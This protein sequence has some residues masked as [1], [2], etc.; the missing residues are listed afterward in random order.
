M[1]IHR[2][3][4]HD[5]KGVSFDLP[6]ASAMVFFGPND[7]G[8]TNTLEAFLSE[9]GPARSVRGQDEPQEIRTELELE[10]DGLAI[11][12]HHDQE[13][14]LT[15]LLAHTFV[16]PYAE[17]DEGSAG[18]HEVLDRFKAYREAAF[19][20][21]EA[22]PF[23][24]TRPD[25]VARLVDEVLEQLGLVWDELI[26]VGADAGELAA[27]SGPRL[28]Q[29]PRF[30]MSF[31]RIEWL[32]PGDRHRGSEYVW[33]IE[34]GGPPVWQRY[35]TDNLF[36]PTGITVVPVLS[37]ADNFAALQAR[38]EELVLR[39]AR[40]H[41]SEA[42]FLAAAEGRQAEEGAVGDDWMVQLADAF[43]LRPSVL[44]ACGDV[45]Q[46]VN[47][48]AP[49]FLGQAYE[50]ELVPVG[51]GQPEA[52]AGQHLAVRLHARGRHFTVERE[53]VSSGVAT[54]LDLTLSEAVRDIEG[55]LRREDPWS[56]ES[57]RRAGP[58][59]YVFDEPERHLHPLAQEQ[60]AAWIA[61]R[62]AAGADILLATH[63]LPF[64]DLPMESVEYFSVERCAQDWR[65]TIERI[66]KDKLG[67][68]R[69]ATTAMGLPPG[70]AFQLVREWL[71]VEGEH[72]RLILE[73]FHGRDL[74]QAGVEIIPLRGFRRAEASFAMVEALKCLGRPF[75]YMLDQTRQAALDGA[76]IGEARS[77]EEKVAEQL[78]R[79]RDDPEVRLELIAWPFPD[80][81]CGLPMDAV[82]GVAREKAKKAPV[83]ISWEELIERYRQHKVDAQ[84]AGRKPHDFKRFVLGHLGL[85]SMRAD[86]FIE[87]V[88]ERCASHPPQATALGRKVA[89]LIASV[90]GVSPAGL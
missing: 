60:A 38:L 25:L 39:L 26:A 59:I 63:A 31:I 80:I 44:Q 20:V 67:A 51:P 74:R 52:A 76:V 2:V 68:V 24:G 16:E 21:Y 11:P 90:Q 1:R 55:E 79:W 41:R 35:A 86:E 72:D 8:K 9:F 82:L 14:F 70:A 64:F 54:W 17:S 50:V 43:V 49:P 13:V 48:L 34:M 40:R 5:Y 84:T 27:Y 57:L 42:A 58:M 69:R 12:G 37:A 19:E 61:R 45:A 73:A 89:A 71:V 10:L 83:P 88:L 30:D 6:W 47:E 22:L 28:V 85:A 62:A 32:P 56:E 18:G 29:S 4:V 33:A 66:T 3:R 46:R 77:E 53:L 15:W 65:T 78:L 81:I 23:D 87:L 36:G 7:S 75:C